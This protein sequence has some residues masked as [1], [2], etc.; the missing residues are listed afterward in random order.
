MPAS[1]LLVQ[2][3]ILAPLTSQ[4]GFPTT[5]D[6]VSPIVRNQAHPESDQVDIS[7]NKLQRA[8]QLNGTNK[9]PDRSKT[10]LVAVQRSFSYHPRDCCP[11]RK[12]GNCLTFG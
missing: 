5:Y 2:E 10:H 3:Q 7:W 9:T 12:L 11:S 6:S 4:E 8:Q 1:R